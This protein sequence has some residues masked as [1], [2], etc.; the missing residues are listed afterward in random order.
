MPEPQRSV[1]AR[2][3]PVVTLLTA[4]M[5]V[6]APESPGQG[7][8]IPFDT[9]LTVS[10]CDTLLSLPHRFI[11]PASFVLGIDSVKLS[12]PRDFT[13]GTGD[14]S[15]RL[16]LPDSV[17]RSLMGPSPAALNVR[18]RYLPFSFRPEY[19]LRVPVALPDTA[20]GRVDTMYR[21]ASDFTSEDFF[22]SRLSR[23]GSLIRGIEAGTNR[24]LTLNSGFRLQMSGKLTDDLELLAALTDENTPLQPEGTTETLQELDRVFIELRSPRAAA[25]VGDLSLGFSSG[26]FGRLTRKL[27]GALASYSDSGRDAGGVV[28]AGGASVRGKYSRNEFPGTD[29]VQ[30]PYRLQGRN[31]ET[32]VIVIAG[33]EHVYIDG[34]EMARGQLND[35]TIDYGLGEITFTSRRRI[36]FAS[37]IVVEFEYTDRRYSRDLLGG[38][39]NFAAGAGGWGIG[40]MIVQERDDPDSPVDIQLSGADRA[41]LSSAGDSQVM[42]SRSGVDSVGPG[43]GK[44]E[45]RDTLVFFPAEGGYR[46]TTV[47]VFN[48]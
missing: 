3:R 23:S 29:A 1:F 46:D 16:H 42:A 19:T 24:D 35:Y 40:G 38:R 31:N 41:V 28:E 44:Y 11:D 13:P 5:T 45:L 20:T 8:G 21:T 4:I 26:R 18:Y 37:R 15:L 34:A 47:L 7:A 6:P 9:L 25:T 39:G 30:G 27:R 22:G 32:P 10:S 43:N 33:T 12:F 2:L 14:G 17:C 36:T 48:P